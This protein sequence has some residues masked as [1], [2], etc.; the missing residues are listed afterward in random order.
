MLT[1]TFW[2]GL[3]IVLVRAT[4]LLYQHVLSIGVILV[5][6]NDLEEADEVVN[7]KILG[8]LLDCHQLVT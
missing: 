5:G 2:I 7:I 3:S 6:K 4:L 8:G 1:T